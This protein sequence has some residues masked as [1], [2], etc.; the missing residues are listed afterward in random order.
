ML[1]KMDPTP[2]W[3]REWDRLRFLKLNKNDGYP[4]KGEDSGL[5]ICPADDEY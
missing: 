5:D 1:L 2:D 4:G 3:S